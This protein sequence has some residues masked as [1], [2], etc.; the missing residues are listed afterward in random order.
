MADATTIKS[1]KVRVLLDVSGGG[2][3]STK[4]GF[5]QQGITFTKGLEEV[6]IPDCDDPDA[7]PWLGRD[8]VS[9]S[10]AV[11]GEG[12]VAVESF[13]D[14]L[15]AATSTDSV[16]AKVEIE[17]PA[18]T[19]TYTGA[20]HVETVEIARQNGRRVTFTTSM[21]SDGEFAKSTT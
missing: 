17:F 7:V 16:A 9:L 19:L 11:S 8:A 18:K 12:V 10:L 20:L 6:V 14:L 1:G 13:E 15:D 2:T 5:N 4:C 21:Q 3:Y